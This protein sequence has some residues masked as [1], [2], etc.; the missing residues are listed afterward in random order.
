MSCVNWWN[1]CKKCKT[2]TYDRERQL[3]CDTCGEKM[4]SIREWDEEND[5]HEVE[6]DDQ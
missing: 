3:T 6:G 4:R 2:E 1:E 5:H